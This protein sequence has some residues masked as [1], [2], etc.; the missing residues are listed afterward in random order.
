MAAGSWKRYNAEEERFVERCMEA[1]MAGLPAPLRTGPAL[2]PWP[3]AS[4]WLRYLV[5]GEMWDGVPGADG[6]VPWKRVCCPASYTNHFDFA[7]HMPALLHAYLHTQRLVRVRLRDRRFSMLLPGAPTH[8]PFFQIN[9]LTNR[10]FAIVSQGRCLPVAESEDGRSLFLLDR[11][12]ALRFA[13]SPVLVAD[14]ERLFRVEPVFYSRKTAA[15]LID[16]L[17][18]PVFGS[19]REMLTHFCLK[20]APRGEGDELSPFS[21]LRPEAPP[22]FDWE[23]WLTPQPSA[24]EAAPPQ[25]ANA[26]AAR[27]LATHLARIQEKIAL[28]RELDPGFFIRGADW[29]HHRMDPMLLLEE[30]SR[31][32]NAQGCVLP[33]AYAQFLLTVGNGGIGPDQGLWRVETSDPQVALVCGR[34]QA[35]DENRLRRPFPHRRL[36]NPRMSAKGSVT[37]Q[38]YYSDQQISGTVFLGERPNEA[39]KTVTLLLVV[40]GPEQGHLWTDERSAKMGIRPLSRRGPYSFLAWYERGLDLTI[41]DIQQL[42]EAYYRDVQ[43]GP[44]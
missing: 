9:R 18:E 23:P 28:L 4:D 31:F 1:H 21:L 7:D 30:R 10:W 14:T 29:H 43:K 35:L 38:D 41:E 13:D 15:D 24:D 26:I 25:R 36:W 37:E 11:R 22:P 17:A 12:A 39:G 20:N 40:A 44:R 3:G 42:Y 27:D 32:E 19:F 16:P 33:E 5:P 2:P 34:T 8:A 6:L